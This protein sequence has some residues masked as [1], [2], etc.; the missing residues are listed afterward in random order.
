[1]AHIS[2]PIKA[3]IFD[4]DGTLID[5][6]GTHLAAWQQVMRNR[7][8]E[9]TLQQAASFPGKPGIEIARS[10]TQVTGEQDPDVLLQEKCR[11]Y[12]VLHKQGLPPITGT[13]DF[14]KRVAQE[15][16]RLG[17]KIGVA[18]AAPRTELLHNLHYLGIDMLCDLV[19][20]GHEDLHHYHDPEGVNKPKPYIYL[21]SAK[22]LEVLPQHCVVLED[23]TTGVM[24][25][26]C[27]GCMTVA[28]PN[29]FT[30]HHDLSHAILALETLS[31]IS[32]EE[33]L[34]K[35]RASVDHTMCV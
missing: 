17:L 18:S 9:L 23:S 15:K 33:F 14:L 22:I 31:D 5:S 2:K 12:D 11:C 25:G 10:L 8:H 20:S 19:L 21:E 30:K 27:A 32:V 26:F 28:L 6:E 29:Q 24:A 35:V 7:G 3:L 1:M 4:C 13:V 34:E 16:K